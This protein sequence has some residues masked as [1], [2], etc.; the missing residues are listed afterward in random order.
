MLEFGALPHQLRGMDVL[1]R[2]RAV[3]AIVLW[4][5]AALACGSCSS[6]RVTSSPGFDFSAFDSFA[7]KQ[8]PKIETAKSTPEDRA[9]LGRV[10]RAIEQKLSRLGVR[11]TTPGQ[12]SVHVDA[13]LGVELKIQNNDPYFALYVAEK[14]EEGM[15]RIRLLDP[16]SGDAI[17][18]GEREHRL[19]Y[20]SR[21]FGGIKPEW[22]PTGEGRQWRVDQM[23]EQI[24]QRAAD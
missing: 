21:T 11:E 19:R 2:S 22:H 15:L 4:T 12:A 16:K 18:S 10:E 6:V 7:W 24:L 9:V 17:W 14:Y 1:H 23:V 20:V 3:A 5:C 13:T 8:R